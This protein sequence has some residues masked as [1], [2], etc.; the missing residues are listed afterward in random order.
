MK[1][2]CSRKS[3]KQSGGGCGCGG[4]PTLGFPQNG[5]GLLD[6]LF[7][8]ESKSN[9]NSTLINSLN[10]P[11]PPPMPSMSSSTPSPRTSIKNIASVSS[12]GD[13]TPVSSTHSRLAAVEKKLAALETSGGKGFFGGSRHM[14]RHAKR[15]TKR[16]THRR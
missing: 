9:I 7:N 5:G 2:K 12:K 11:R 14:K 8:T 4:A 13:E 6:G 10:S 3:R 16:R 1:R 15:H